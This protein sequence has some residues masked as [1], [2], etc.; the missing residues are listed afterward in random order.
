MKKFSICLFL[1]FATMGMAQSS[2]MGSVRD[3]YIAA[4]NSKDA[5]KVAALYATDAV[6]I[7]P[8]G[9]VRGR[10]AIREYVQ[11]GFAQGVTNLQVNSSASG[12]DADMQWESGDVTEKMGGQDVKGHYLVT[13]KMSGGQWMIVALAN[14]PATPQH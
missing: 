8:D 11:K 1:L 9:V 4:F 13:L 2:K 3:A 12:G 6:L 7:V 14:V 5:T 10:D